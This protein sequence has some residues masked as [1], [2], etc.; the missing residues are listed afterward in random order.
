ML[1]QILL[2]AIKDTADPKERNTLTVQL[3]FV[4]NIH[5][6][7]LSRIE[8]IIKSTNDPTDPLILSYGAVASSLSPQLQSRVV[9]FLHNR[10]DKDDDD[11]SIHL[12]HAMGNMKSNLTDEHF[13][14]S[15][16]H[17][18]PSIRLA[19]IYALRQR[20]DSPEIR[21]SLLRTL[22]SFPSREVTEMTLKALIAGAEGYH[23]YPAVANDSLFEQLVTA[24]EGDIEQ[25]AMLAYYVRLLGPLSPKH[26]LP[27]VGSG[28]Q[29]R[30]KVWNENKN[31]YNLVLDYETRNKDVSTYPSHKAYLWGKSLGNSK[32]NMAAS[33]GAFAG[34][35]AGSAEAPG[36]FKLFAKGIVRGQAFGRSKTAFEALARSENEPG[37]GNIKNK[38]YLSIVGIVLLNL[39]KEIPACSPWGLPLFEGPDFPLIDFNFKLFIFVGMLKFRLTVT[40]ILRLDL[41]L[42]VC[43][44]ECITAKGR[45]TPSVGF[46]AVAEA[47]A[48]I[49]VSIWNL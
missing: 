42:T 31:E 48:V 33:F 23:S 46:S 3:A 18:N 37:S 44:K 12:I 17:E 14:A 29:R 39:E 7:M 10:V 38:L 13:I 2:Q 22:R 4:P 25:R 19:A 41:A 9:R 30:G 45:I 26:W 43:V 36:G 16:S 35:A 21:H 8:D 24:T 1:A 34:V 49:L 27:M 40:A 28:R 15:L 47:G 6:D 5:P 20:T 32:I 11:T